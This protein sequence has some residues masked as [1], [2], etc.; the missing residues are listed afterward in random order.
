MECKLSRVNF[1]RV[2]DG[3]RA[4]RPA[5]KVTEIYVDYYRSTMGVIVISLA[6]PRSAREN[7]GF[8]LKGLGVPATSLGAPATTLGA[9]LFT[10]EQSGK[11]IF[12][13][14]A[15]G[16]PGM[17]QVCLECCRCAWN[18]A[19][20]PGMLQVRLE[21]IATIY[22][23]TIVKIHVLRLYSHLFI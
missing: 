23:A 21:P 12:L 19:G 14:N 7:F 8:I 3:R 16:V 9:P 18:A 4:F 5:F 13:V 17:L 2:L 6:T 10:V 20:A 11:N 15:T 22:R 1:R